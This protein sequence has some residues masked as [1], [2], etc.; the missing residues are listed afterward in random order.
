MTVKARTDILA[1]LFLIVA[2]VVLGISIWV[3]GSE[4][5]IF[6]RQ[7]PFRVTFRDVKGLSEGAP[8]RLGG[9]TIGRI[10][11]IGFSN[12]LSDP[13]VHV[14]ILIN[15]DY[16]ERIR[17]DSEAVIETQGLLGDKFISVTP[18]SKL[19]EV[20]PGAELKG[21][22]AADISGLITRAQT[23]VENTVNVSENFKQLVGELRA[24]S[25]KEVTSTFRTASDLL[26]Q[27]KDGDGLITQLI[28]SK[29]GGQ[30]I[31]NNLK[32]TSKGLKDITEGIKNGSG[33]LHTLVY[34][35]NGPQ[36]VAALQEA[37]TKIGDAS[38]KLGDTLEQAKQGNG[39]LHTLLYSTNSAQDYEQLVK[40]LHDTADNLK[41][42]TD[43]LAKGSGTLGALLIDAKVYD[44]MVEVTDEAKRSYLLRSLIRQSLNREKE[45]AATVSQR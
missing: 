11:K 1:G 13:R 16:L 42:A 45:A 21:V 19:G 2:L 6:R 25:L 35:E 38:K 5:Q 43:A 29:K 37:F 33:V 22:D 10:S 20:L 26:K 44:N 34:G 40:K 31:L 14:T 4:R 12:T 17:E 27:I 8:V 15:Q 24:E 18:G 36:T 9:I 3:I 32:D 23:V 41:S 30:E 39:V 28:Y 7:T